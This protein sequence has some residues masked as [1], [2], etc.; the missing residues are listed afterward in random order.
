[1]EIGTRTDDQVQIL[2]GL[3]EGDVVATTSLARLR[4]GLEVTAATAP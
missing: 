2:R 3:N 1:V 4:P